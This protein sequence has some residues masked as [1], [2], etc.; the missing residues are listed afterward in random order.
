MKKLLFLLCLSLC[1]AHIAAGQKLIIGSD[2]PSLK[3]IE[4][5]TAPPVKGVAS[6][7]D[8]Y[9]PSNPSCVKFLDRLGLIA[10]EKKGR[11]QVVLLTRETGAEIDKLVADGR[12]IVGYDPTG[13]TYA[14]YYVKYL[15]YSML[16]DSKGDIAWIG[17]MANLP[18]TTLDAVK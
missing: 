2:A 5:Q 8:F 7:V 14:E 18:T 13:N 11:V 16:V 4:W 9:Q 12:F 1:C 3:E 17:N 6:L 10:K 15:P